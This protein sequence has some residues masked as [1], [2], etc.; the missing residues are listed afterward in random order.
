MEV[1]KLDSCLGRSLVAVC[2]I[3]RPEKRCSDLLW[4]SGLG[5]TARVR[6]GPAGGK[7]R[8]LGT[9]LAAIS[10]ETVVKAKGVD[11][12]AQRTCAEGKRP[13]TLG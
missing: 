2:G 11:G 13:K 8:E 9:D 1:V 10:E 6:G 12:I 7:C 3:S 5:R 4:G